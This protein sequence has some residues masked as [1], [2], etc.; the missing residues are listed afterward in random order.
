MAAGTWALRPPAA[1]TVIDV[2]ADAGSGTTFG[3]TVVAALVPPPP[4]PHA[5][6]PSPSAKARARA[7][8]KAADHGCFR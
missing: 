7:R 4:D 2:H 1:V 3:G 8:A 5:A 6:S